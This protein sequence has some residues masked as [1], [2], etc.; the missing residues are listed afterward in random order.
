VGQF[1]RR[2]QEI[3]N[4]WITLADGCRLAARIWLPTDAD[5]DPVPAILEFLPY[6]KRD[7]TTARDALTIDPD[8]PLS[9]RM[10]THWTETFGRGDWY[11]RV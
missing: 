4:Q 3:E 1:P 2:V 10:E 11:M 6:R 5:D 8:D 9:A 7:G